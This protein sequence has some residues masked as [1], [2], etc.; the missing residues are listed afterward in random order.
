MEG[1]LPKKKKCKGR[2]LKEKKKN[3]QM[4]EI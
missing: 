4:Q 3:Q 1:D 2:V